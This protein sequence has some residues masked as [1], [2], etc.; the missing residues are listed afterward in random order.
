[1]RFLSYLKALSVSIHFV[2]LDGGLIEQS[3]HPYI[4]FLLISLH[5]KQLQLAQEELVKLLFEV[6]SYFIIWR[7]QNNQ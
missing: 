5:K 7:S 1:M 3:N 6:K 4:N 2:S